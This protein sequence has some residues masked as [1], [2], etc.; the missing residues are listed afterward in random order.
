MQTVEITR[1]GNLSVGA[2][3]AE[4]RDWL[5][6]AGIKATELQAVRILKG[7]IVFS[8]TFA[9]ASDAERLLRAFDDPRRLPYPP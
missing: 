2:H 9:L 8:A 4:I 6:R 7:R 1:A 5:D 3:L